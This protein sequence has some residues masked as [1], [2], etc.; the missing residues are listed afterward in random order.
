M[1]NVCL[2]GV[3]PD[4]GCR[5]SPYYDVIKVDSSLWPYS[6]TGRRTAV[7]RYRVL[8]SPALPRRKGRGCTADPS[9]FIIHYTCCIRLNIFLIL[10]LM[11]FCGT[12]F[13]VI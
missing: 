9:V 11:S 4:R 12:L 5:V 7:S 10:C 6:S 8:W 1:T 3:A 13:A 2:F